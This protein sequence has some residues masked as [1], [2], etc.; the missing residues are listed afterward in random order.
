VR[1]A[2]GADRR[3]G[4]DQLTDERPNYELLSM[5]CEAPDSQMGE[6]LVDMLRKLLPSAV[7]QLGRVADP[8]EDEVARVRR[9]LHEALDLAAYSSLASGFVM[10]VLDMEWRRLGGSPDDPAPWREG[11]PWNWVQDGTEA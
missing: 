6:T 9:G 4:E 5:L 11:P 2:D 8:D 7:E 3:E 10:Q 1:L